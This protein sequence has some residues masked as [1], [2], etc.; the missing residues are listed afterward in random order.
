MFMLVGVLKDFYPLSLPFIVQLQTREEMALDRILFCVVRCTP[1][2]IFRK[3]SQTFDLDSQV[4]DPK[5]YR[6]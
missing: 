5:W 6:N 3:V 2:N 1:K 4:T